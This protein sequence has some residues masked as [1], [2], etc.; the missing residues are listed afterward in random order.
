MHA[1]AWARACTHTHTL[2]HVD[3]Q[4]Y[5]NKDTNPLKIYKLLQTHKHMKVHTNTDVKCDHTHGQRYTY[6]DIT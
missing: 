1:H 4:T 5:N 3:V 6:T 2:M